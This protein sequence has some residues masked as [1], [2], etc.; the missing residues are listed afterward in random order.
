MNNGQKKSII[1]G[2]ALIMYLPHTSLCI[3]SLTQPILYSI[4]MIKPA[5][6]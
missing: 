3:T 2:Q 5:N 6:P 4:Y 1:I